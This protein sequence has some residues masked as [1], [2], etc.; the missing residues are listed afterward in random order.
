[1]EIASFDSDDFASL[2]SF[3]TP[4]WHKTYSFLPKAQVEL[5]IDKYFYPEGISHYL[6]IGYEYRKLTDAASHIGVLVY[7][8]KGD[9]IYLDKLYLTEEARGLGYATDAFGWLLSF[10]KDVTLNVN[11]SNERA[12]ACYKKNGFVIENEEYISLGDG[13]VNK[14]FNMRLT[15]ANFE[16]QHSAKQFLRIPIISVEKPRAETE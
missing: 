12:V 9:S 10:G 3:M 6:S 11:Q 5:L 4:I 8:D 1:M 14:D 16:A 15:K 7:F 13:M 2:K